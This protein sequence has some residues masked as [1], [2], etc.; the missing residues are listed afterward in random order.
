MLLV[1]I[2]GFRM[3]Q[4]VNIHAPERSY[5]HQRNQL[6]IGNARMQL[7]GGWPIRSK[8]LLCHMTSAV[9]RQICGVAALCR[10]RRWGGEQVRVRLGRVHPGVFILPASLRRLELPASLRRLEMLLRNV[11]RSLIPSDR[12]QREAYRESAAKR[13]SPRSK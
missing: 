12:A 9:A 8:A 11:A 5:S 4:G 7:L 6:G 1:N 10:A 13:S 3:L 2:P